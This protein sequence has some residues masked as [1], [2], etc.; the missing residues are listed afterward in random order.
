MYTKCRTLSESLLKIGCAKGEISLCQGSEVWP[1]T[2]LPKN[3]RLLSDLTDK[4]TAPLIYASVSSVLA[5]YGATPPKE[6]LSKGQFFSCPEILGNPEIRSPCEVTSCYFHTENTWS[7]NCILS[8]WTNTCVT[9]KNP[10]EFVRRTMT[11]HELSFL[12][13]V[14]SNEIRSNLLEALSK[15]RSEALQETL[16]SAEVDKGPSHFVVPDSFCAVC[17]VRA[18]NPYTRRSG[19]VWCSDACW[20]KKP[21]AAVKLEEKFS[22]PIEKI[23]QSAVQRFGS[24]KLRAS[25]LGLSSAAFENLCNLL[26]ISG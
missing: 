23:L 9:E 3:I 25:S 2:H 14:P 20:N 26:N 19:F 4:N 12:L 5:E 8:Y 6:E 11:N 7:N 13:G 24:T 22:M 10:Q 15:L 21:V 16:D 18:P 17:G 1:C